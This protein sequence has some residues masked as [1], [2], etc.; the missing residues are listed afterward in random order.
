MA[1]PDFELTLSRPVADLRQWDIS[2][3]HIGRDER[4]R[5]CSGRMT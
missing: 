4:R 1:E 5:A 3:S 2:L